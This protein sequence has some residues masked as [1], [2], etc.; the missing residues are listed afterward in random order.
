MT[1]KRK[2]RT[3]EQIAAPPRETDIGRPVLGDAPPSAAYTAPEQ[4]SAPP[5]ERPAP[6][7]PLKDGHAYAEHV[8]VIEHLIA[9]AA[10]A[11]LAPSAIQVGPVRL[12]LAGTANGPSR[13]TDIGRPDTTDLYKQIGGPLWEEYQRR[14]TGSNKEPS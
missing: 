13:I 9:S 3:L 11:G 6:P 1:K 5:I 2:P 8:E 12:E 14:I 7:P 10:A 4:A